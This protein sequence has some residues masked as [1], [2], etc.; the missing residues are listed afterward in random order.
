[1]VRRAVTL[2]LLF[3]LVYAGVHLW[4]G[5]L[6]K[7]M[8]S[9]SAPVKKQLA[10]APATGRKQ[11]KTSPGPK[12]NN[13]DFHV[14]VD[15]NIFEAV[16]VQEGGAKK[17]VAPVVKEEPK[18]TTLKLV[19]QG[20]ISGDERDARAIIVDEKE[21]K[22]DLYQVG[23]AVQGA[24]ITAIERGKVILEFNGRKQFLLIKE[25]KGSGNGG[26]G[27]G[28][29]PEPPTSGLQRRETSFSRGSGGAPV[30]PHRRVSFRPKKRIRRP[31]QEKPGEPALDEGFQE[32]G[33]PQSI[34]PEMEELNN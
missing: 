3:I 9:T 33:A 28:F 8:L 24:L 7:R 11:V 17:T 14:I 34:A 26:T 12:K 27:G 20:T 1:M 16:L 23:D 18:E 13:N 4:Y 2:V 21:K 31:E 10:A 6:E 30:V 19:L 22:Q 32:T 5:R 15:R 25:R 29:I